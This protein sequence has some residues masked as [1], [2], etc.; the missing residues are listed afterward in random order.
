MILFGL[1]EGQAAFGALTIPLV[2]VGDPGNPSD[3]TGFGAV[4]I[5]RKLTCSW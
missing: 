4:A 2:T 3:A 5:A 1:G